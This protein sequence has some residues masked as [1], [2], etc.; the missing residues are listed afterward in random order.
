MP[1]QYN[2]NRPGVYYPGM[3]K[4][5]AA[6]AHL[7]ARTQWY[8]MCR[9]GWTKDDLV[10]KAWLRVGRFVKS[11]EH[12]RKYMFLNAKRSMYIMIQAEHRRLSRIDYGSLDTL[13]DDD[14]MDCIDPL[15]VCYNPSILKDMR[16]L[17]S[18]E[19]QIIYL[20]YSGWLYKDIASA[21]GVS[22]QRVNQIKEQAL[23]KLK[24][25]YDRD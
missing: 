8:T 6:A 3:L 18:R 1:R 11:E 20:H 4:I 22:R 2:K 16:P 7:T 15:A 5:L 10:Q 17:S 23:N 25:Y 9:I 12:M 24:E 19:K 14:N 21:L 13:L